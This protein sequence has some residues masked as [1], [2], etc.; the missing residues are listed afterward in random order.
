MCCDHLL[1]RLANNSTPIN[2]NAA[3]LGSCAWATCSCESCALGEITD[4]D[5]LC[6]EWDKLIFCI[7]WHLLR[8]H[9]LLYVSFPLPTPHPPLTDMPTDFNSFKKVI[10]KEDSAQSTNNNSTFY[11]GTS[12][13]FL[14]CRLI[15]FHCCAIVNHLSFWIDMRKLEISTSIPI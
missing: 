2:N 8:R 11:E 5:A 1:A 4:D 10:R 9:P 12:S 3:A 15:K 14:L 7:A 13:S 6:S